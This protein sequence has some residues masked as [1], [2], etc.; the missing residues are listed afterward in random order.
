MTLR[1]TID[2]GASDSVT[3]LATVVESSV[4]RSLS[5][6]VT[7]D[8]PVVLVATNAL[9][10]IVTSVEV[11]RQTKDGDVLYRV[12][13]VPVRA[14]S[15]SVPFYR[16]L[17]VGARG[18]D[19]AQL[20]RAL[21]KLGHFSGT[22]T[23]RFEWSTSVAVRAW[24]RALEVPVTGRVGFGEVV[25][26][27]RLPGPVRLGDSIV[28]GGRVSGGEPAAHAPSGKLEAYLVVAQGQAAQI[29][30]GSA[31]Q[32]AP[33][34][35]DWPAVVGEVRPTSDGHVRLELTAPDGGPVCA[36]ECDKLP[37]AEQAALPATVTIVPAVTGSAV[38][39][40]AVHT[41]AQGA[42]FVRMASGHQRPV[43]VLGSADGVSVV[44]G[45]S[46]G[47]QVVVLGDRS[48]LGTPLGDGHVDD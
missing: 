14:V 15:G 39:V 12:D 46:V 20:Q 30:P 24:Q 10:G 32:V 29:P 4:G 17:S 36:D 18:D 34:E 27:P 8:Q 19:V 48:G 13:T 44:R 37:A 3:M 9:A 26:I 11:R 41:D 7:L 6:Q 28:R 31:V 43:T 42:A 2:P 40:A 35:L 1:S 23:G 38:P 21:R 33:G 47:E 45:L 25:A 16:D 22:V 5:L